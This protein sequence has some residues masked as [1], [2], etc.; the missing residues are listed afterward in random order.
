METR[1]EKKEKKEGTERDL[2]SVYMEGMTVTMREDDIQDLHSH[3][4]P[5]AHTHLSASKV[6]N[7]MNQ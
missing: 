6:I 1:K 7:Y 3:T 4:R 2:F 5:T